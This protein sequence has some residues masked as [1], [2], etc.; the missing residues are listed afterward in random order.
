MRLCPICN[1]RFEKKFEMG[2]C[3][4]CSNKMEQAKKRIEDNDFKTDVKNAERFSVSSAINKKMM[5]NEEKFFDLSSGESIKN[6]LNRIFYSRIREKTGMKYDTENPDVVFSINLETLDI[7]SKPASL[8]FFGRYKKL[9]KEIAQKRWIYEKFPSIEVIIGEKAVP[10]FEAVDYTMHASGRED[11]D[12]TNTA[13]RPFVMEI[14]EAKRRK[15]DLKKMEQEI[16]KDRRISVELIGYVPS[17]FVY[18]VSD[19]HFDKAYRAHFECEERLD[20][21]DF[22]KIEGLSGKMID[23]QTPIRVMNRRTDKIRQRKVYG[24]SIG[25]DEEGVY[26]DIDCEAGMYIK[27]L[28]NGDEGRT[29]PSFS[30]ATNKK[31]ACRNLIVTRIDDSFLDEAFMNV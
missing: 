13:G 23:Q 9:E 29:D 7:S 4:I 1:E 11:I 27:E 24:I 15:I 26:A 30:K 12:V 2:E 25:N 20:D 31:I 22:E 5:V 21:R 17:S 8:F 14:R 28:V 3:G 16:N 19:S 10:F 6:Q 18:L